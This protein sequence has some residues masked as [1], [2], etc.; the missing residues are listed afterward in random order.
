MEGHQTA[1]KMLHFREH[2]RSNAADR[3]DYEKLKFRLEAENPDGIGQY[4]EGMAPF[5]RAI[6]D[7]SYR[8]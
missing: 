7:R 1:G 2:L 6:L 5:I 8:Q 3:L 4:L